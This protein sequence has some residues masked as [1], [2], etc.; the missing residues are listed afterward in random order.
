V[1]VAASHQNNLL[2]R[3]KNLWAYSSLNLGGGDKIM[4]SF[5]LEIT[6]Q[7]KDEA[8][9]YLNDQHCLIA[10]MLHH[11]GHIVK[12]VSGFAAVTNQGYF[13]FQDVLPSNYYEEED[14]T[15]RDFI[16]CFITVRQDAVGKTITFTKE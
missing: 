9:E 8:K 7:V 10:T 12:S 15:S 11:A 13:T 3:I 16:N 5:T 2:V 1:A 4:V 6:Q 14:K